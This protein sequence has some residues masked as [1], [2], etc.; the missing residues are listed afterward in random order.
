MTLALLTDLLSDLNSSVALSGMLP[1]DLLMELLDYQNIVQDM[2]IRARNL[3]NQERALSAFVGVVAMET[4]DLEDLIGRLAENVSL[5]EEGVARITAEAEPAARLLSQLQETLGAVEEAV[6]VSLVASLN[7][8]REQLLVIQSQF[9]SLVNLSLNA[10]QTA[11]AQYSLAISLLADALTSVTSA[12]EA[13]ELLSETIALQN[14]TSVAIDSLQERQLLL[15]VVFTSASSELREVEVTVPSVL[16]QAK[17]L[18]SRLRNISLGDYD[19]TSLE[20]RADR[21]VNLTRDLESDTAS[22]L[23][24]VEAAE[25]EVAGVRERASL[26]LAEATSLNL[27]AVELLARAHAALSFA[28]ST[29]EEGNKFIASVEQLLSDLQERLGDS[30]GFVNG[31]EEVGS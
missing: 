9:D 24:D 4:D 21:L 29:V 3:T 25:E 5:S 23:A 11:G 31:L 30:Q 16:S 19:T 8:T 13:V 20:A 17:A 14:A 7:E 10:N 2:L 15:D 27:L 26:V 22:V 6:R 1:A 18:L 28:N 12:Q